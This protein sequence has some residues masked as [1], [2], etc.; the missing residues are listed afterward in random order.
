MPKDNTD[1]EAERAPRPDSESGAEPTQNTAAERIRQLVVA[2]GMCG[3]PTPNTA[4]YEIWLDDV[5]QR[6]NTPPPRRHI[7]NAYFFDDADGRRA[8]AALVFA[9]R[10]WAE[11]AATTGMPSVIAVEKLLRL[12]I[13]AGEASATEEERDR[14]Q[15]V[16]ETVAKKAVEYLR[17]WTAPAREE[18]LRSLVRD[19]GRLVA[20]SSGDNGQNFWDQT[21]D[22]I[23]EASV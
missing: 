4:A 7:P 6:S 5:F 22:A 19:T 13:L 14:R 17:S 10:R 20:A 3:M 23:R 12:A 1:P 9:W 11:R 18:L 21:P 8:W 16:V 2:A 15:Q